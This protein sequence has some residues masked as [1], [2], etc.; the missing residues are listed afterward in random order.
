MLHLA[1][2]KNLTFET[3]EDDFNIYKDTSEILKMDL[4][5]EETEKINDD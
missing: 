5:T 1:N 3:V 4:I 2:D